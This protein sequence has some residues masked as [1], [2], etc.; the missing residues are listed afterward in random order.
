MV[1]DGF[2]LSLCYDIRSR[3]SGAPQDL[4]RIVRETRDVRNI[5]ELLQLTIDDGWEG[6][7]ITQ[8]QTTNIH[9]EALQNPLASCLDE[10][11]W[12][13]TKIK[14]STLDSAKGSKPNAVLQALG[15]RLKSREVQES[16]E[17]VTR[18]KSVLTMAIGTHNMYGPSHICTTGWKP[19]WLNATYFPVQGYFGKDWEAHSRPE[20]RHC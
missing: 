4:M 12:I 6:K 19:P 13:G 5:I 20:K 17:R 14:S 16:L 2:I 11:N 15:W 1:L 7:S 9:L 3:L 8:S 18:C 10:L